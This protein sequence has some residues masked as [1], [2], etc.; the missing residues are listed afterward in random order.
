MVW[1]HRRRIESSS[2]NQCRAARPRGRWVGRKLRRHG[3]RPRVSLRCDSCAIRGRRSPTPLTAVPS[4][5]NLPD[6]LTRPIGRADIV[7]MVSSRLQRGRFVTI[8]GPAG[9]GKTT[10]ALAVAEKLAGSYK[11]GARF[12][13]LAPLTDPPLVPS[14]LASVLGVAMRS[15]NPYP[16]LTSF[17]RDREMLLLF[18]NC[19]HVLLA[20]AALTEELL[21][22][23][24]DI[25]VLATSREPL[26][27]E[28][29]RVQRL[30]PLELAPPA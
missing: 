14:A 5:H 22:G 3:A 2:S 29:E 13:D 27:A 12:V 23:A 11:D 30:P 26:R 17:L 7:A 25:Q 6:R 19:E 1:L 28:D 18:D 8:V 4:G 24:P 21:K 20:A 15:D 10:V 16:A 9:V